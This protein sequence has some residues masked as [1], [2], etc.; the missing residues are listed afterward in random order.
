MRLVKLYCFRRHSPWPTKNLIKKYGLEELAGKRDPQ[1]PPV[2]GCTQKCTDEHFAQAFDGSVA[3]TQLALLDPQKAVTC[4]SNAFIEALAGN[5]V[6]LTDAPL[7]SSSSVACI[8]N[9]NC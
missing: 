3:R 1:N 5:N 2:G 7:R 8:F 4:A 6:S 9:R